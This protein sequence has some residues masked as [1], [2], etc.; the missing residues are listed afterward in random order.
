MANSPVR[1][2]TR[3][4]PSPAWTVVT[5][6]P[7]KGMVLAREAGSVFAWDEADQLYRIDSEGQFQSV[8]R[9]P[10]K[11]QGGAISDDG[12]L[13]AL[14]GEGSRLWL[15]DGDFELTHERAT[16]ADP[17]AIAV[18]PHG[19]YVAVS[20][21]MN[22]VQFYS[23][24]ARLSGKFETRQPLASMVFV[25]DRL[26]MVATGAYG[27]IVGIAMMAR[28]N[29]SLEGAIVWN[30]ALMSGVGRLATTGDG[31]MILLACFTHGVQRYDIE[32]KS[33][34]AYHLGGSAGHAVPDFAGR[35]IAV[36]TME[37]ELAILS[38]AG[39][40]KW[41]TSLKRPA[42][43]LE[44]D[45]LG[46]YVVYGQA[47]GEVVRL[48]LQST[49]RPAPAVSTARSSSTSSKNG[50]SK[51]RIGNAS[52]RVPEWTAEVVQ[53]DDQAEFAV[54]AVSE[55]PTRIGVITHK[56]RLEL[57]G[58]DGKR[59]GQAPE[60]DGVGRIVRT[61]PGWMA[62][63]TDRRIVLCD[64]KRNLAQRVDVSLAELTHLVILPDSY[65]LALVQERD[66]I[67]RATPAGRWIWK[68]EL[69][70]PI[71]E[72]AIDPAGY[73]AVTLEDGL[74][75]VY[76]PAGAIAGEFR[77]AQSDPALL[78]AAPEG[79]AVAWL[80]LA[81]RG[82][83]L[84]GH[85]RS[86][87]VAWE[88]P[89]PWEAWQFLA[90]GSSAVVVAPDGRAV[91]FDSSGHALAQGRADGVPETFCLGLDGKPLRVTRQGVHL[92]CSDLGG[93]VAWRAV[94]EASI[95]PLAAGKDGL[96]VLIG[97]SIAWFPFNRTT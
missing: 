82:Q 11:I 14:L 96:A 86:G 17:L 25:P 80:T 44:T 57:F 85:E 88:S 4:D 71:E 77:G 27:S 8:A 56:N 90:V 74:L 68:T 54:V 21:K 43:A 91:A 72:I 89:V 39:N 51:S 52:V 20:S 30:E 53:T 61:A 18:D 26:F 10:G 70:S 78:I 28:G 97:K 41:R 65:G 69:S 42:M 60:I 47:T 23:K 62:A 9:A 35:S 50:A 22:V 32:G 36:S 49:G 81:R 24:H 94:A 16:I 1:S 76:N 75:R 67:G 48:D 58:P 6:A 34:G 38:G 31:Q 73:T 37:G 63:A 92:I 83:V 45:A 2:S 95:G 19:R 87:R 66:R 40:V 33:E 59:L 29:G 64:L 55:G 5:D 7:L 84:R 13:V 46:R 79:S 15:L 3:L 93:G 12:S